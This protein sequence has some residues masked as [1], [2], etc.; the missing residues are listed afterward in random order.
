MVTQIIDV[1]RKYE[2]RVRSMENVP[3]FSYD[4][5]MLRLDGG[6]NRSFFFYLFTNMAMAIEFMMEIGL[7]LIST[8]GIYDSFFYIP[9]SPKIILRLGF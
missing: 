1:I 4:R 8:L 2:E 3:R 7:L 5:R 6:Q 9:R